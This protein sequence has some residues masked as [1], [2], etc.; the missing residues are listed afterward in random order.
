MNGE[1]LSDPAS[2]PLSVEKRVDEACDR[3]EA[4]WKKQPPPRI[5]DYLA[6]TPEPERAAL[7]RPLLSLEIE[8]R[9]KDGEKPAPEEYRQRL[10]NHIEAINAVFAEATTPQ[11]LTPTVAQARAAAVRPAPSTLAWPK[12]AGYE[13]LAEVGRGGMGVVFK[14]RQ[15][16]PNRLVALKMIREGALAGPE[17]LRRFLIEAEAAAQ[18][19]HPN[20]ARVYEVGEHE[21]MPYIAMEFAEGGGLDKK[22]A[23]QPLPP[24]EAAELVRTLADAVHY[25]HEKRI[26][27]RDL[28]PANIVLTADGRPLI[29]DF[30]LAKRLDSGTAMTVSEQVLGTAGYMAP[31]LAEGQAKHVGPAADI[32][33]LGAILYETLT[34]MPP[35][36][37]ATWYDTAHAVLNEEP[38]PPTLR[39]PDVPADL[40]TICLKCLEKKN[41]D[42]Y[43][44]ARGLAEDL[45][46]FLENET[47]LAAP[48]SR[49]ENY[50]A[51]YLRSWRRSACA[52]WPRVRHSVIPAP[53]PWQTNWTACRCLKKSEALLYSVPWV[54]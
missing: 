35:L 26:V 41:E 45:R 54:H 22:L 14:A 52:A 18:F 46:R 47:I 1:F 21:G 38:I 27:H 4:A 31:E 23:A 39:Q 30:G 51:T 10:P 6:G 36:R 13:V 37:G 2:L 24:R 34:G 3:F 43:P 20:L 9:C 12:I 16:R 15:L 5:E 29:T 28:K 8:L 50:V 42:R 32:Y 7:L 17:H 33:A 25:A 53:A 19:Q 49:P 44:S 48:I 40:E 11:P